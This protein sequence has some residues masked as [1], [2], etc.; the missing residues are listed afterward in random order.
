MWCDVDFDLFDNTSI[1][2]QASEIQQL[3]LLLTNQVQIADIL[4]IVVILLF[5]SDTSQNDAYYDQI[6]KSAVQFS[7][8]AHYTPVTDEVVV[9]T[10][11]CSTS[12][13]RRNSL[14]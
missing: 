12:E 3:G 4:K 13:C 9:V 5:I 6:V 10:A 14:P 1:V 2:W 8:V 11:A 7:P